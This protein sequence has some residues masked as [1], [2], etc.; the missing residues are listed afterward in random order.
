MCVCMYMKNITQ[1]YI[2]IYMCVLIYT[3]YINGMS[4]DV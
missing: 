4:D 2:F 3:V 1:I